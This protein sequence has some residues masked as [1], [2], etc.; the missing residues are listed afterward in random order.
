ME[1][2]KEPV[3]DILMA[4]YNGEPFLEAQFDSI[5]AQTFENYRLIIRD[6]GSNDKTLEIIEKYRAKFGEKMLVVKDHHQNLGCKLNFGQLMHHASAPWVMFSD[7]D[8]VWLPHK[9]EQTYNTAQALLKKYNPSMPLMVHGDLCVVSKDLEV[10]YPSFKQVRNLNFEPQSLGQMLMQCNVAGC[11]M[12]MN[13]ALVQMAKNIPNQAI[14]HDYWVSLVNGLFGQKEAMVDQKIILYRQHGNNE[15]AG[16]YPIKPGIL[17][18]WTLLKNRWKTMP[19][20]RWGM[21]SLLQELRKEFSKN[22]H[23][24]TALLESFR[25]NLSTQQIHIIENFISL[26]QKNWWRRR[27]AII[28]YKFLPS[29]LFGKVIFFLFY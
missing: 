19:K 12:M 4:T 7:Q 16:Q 29:T 24:A 21:P 25:E 8:D 15:M 17:F 10:I 20:N 5:L 13:Q 23:Q 26:P 2:S 28:K 18:I 14:M 27:R 9:V 6:D 22:I 11:T 3:V 1:V